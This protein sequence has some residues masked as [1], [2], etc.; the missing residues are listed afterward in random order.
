M[1][2]VLSVR[3]AQPAFAVERSKE[4]V[5]LGIVRV[6]LAR[7]VLVVLVRRVVRVQRRVERLLLE[8]VELVLARLPLDARQRLA[9]PS[10]NAVDARC[11]C[12]QPREH[13]EDVHHV[14]VQLVRDVDTGKSRL[15]REQRDLVT[16]HL[17]V[18]ALDQHRRQ[19]TQVTKQ[20]RS[21]WVR[22]VRPDAV[23]AK[24][25]SDGV[26]MTVEW[27]QRHHIAVA[28]L[29]PRATGHGQVDPRR[30]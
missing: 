13:L 2:G 21:I 4:G 18:T 16:E 14:L 25:A 6:G 23:R 26:Q 24:V 28:V 9:Y 29:L 10:S 15:V 19:I 22:D 27:G 11:C 8:V 17:R 12:G 20:R 5:L 30:K 3:A 7:L 1:Q